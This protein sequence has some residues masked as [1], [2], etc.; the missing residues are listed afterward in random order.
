MF[1]APTSKAMVRPMRLILLALVA[2]LVGFVAVG[3]G[4]GQ[5]A[6][7]V[8]LPV[9]HEL[10]PVA[11]ATEKADSARFETEF[12]FRMLSMPRGW[13]SPAPTCS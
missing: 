5:G 2:A 3:C 9:L 8:A 11:D 13:R 7:A 10:G 1:R 6:T 4:S 12:E